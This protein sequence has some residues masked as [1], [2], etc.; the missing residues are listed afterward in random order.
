M[1]KEFEVLEV[2]ADRYGDVEDTDHLGSIQLKTDEEDIYEIIREEML[3]LGLNVP[4]TWDIIR[5]EYMGLISIYDS[6]GRYR[7]Q[8][9]GF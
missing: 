7:Y 8:L 9:R 3:N 6:K 4:H 1:F 2:Y 5:D